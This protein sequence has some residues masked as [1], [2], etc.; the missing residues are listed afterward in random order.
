MKQQARIAKA[1]LAIVLSIV[2]WL[3]SSAFTNRYSYAEADELFVSA[4]RPQSRNATTS[5]NAI[6][7]LEEFLDNMDIYVPDKIHLLTWDDFDYIFGLGEIFMYEN[8]TA[9]EEEINDFLR[10]EMLRLSAEKQNSF[11]RFFWYED[12]MT[13]ET[14]RLSMQNP[15]GALDVRND[16]AH[17]RRMTNYFYYQGHFQGNA[18]AF[19]HGFWNALMIRSVGY[20]WAERFATA[21]ESETVCQDDLHMD[22]QNN[23]WGR[24]DGQTYRHLT[25]HQLAYQIMDYVT[26]GWYIRIHNNDGVLTIIPTNRDDRWFNHVW[27]SV[28]WTLRQRMSDGSNYSRASSSNDSAAFFDRTMLLRANRLP[29][30]IEGT[31]ANAVTVFNQPV[32]LRVNNVTA[33]V[34]IDGGRSVDIDGTSNVYVGHMNLHSG[35]R[36]HNLGHRVGFGALLVNRNGEIDRHLQDVFI[37]VPAG[38]YLL[39]HDGMFVFGTGRHTITIYFETRNG[40]SWRNH[41]L[42]FQFRVL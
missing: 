19:R 11:T 20:I 32:I 40:L 13:A 42:D 15:L 9:T 16:A 30:R 18:D 41:R 12:N 27:R 37:S 23:A 28:N 24:M 10:N 14:R 33:G 25:T 4:G 17:A 8:P 3:G 29:T 34:R 6:Q 39:P 1:T 7:N 31:G 21:H 5:E 22:L 36:L 35:A 26:W 38:D 2:M